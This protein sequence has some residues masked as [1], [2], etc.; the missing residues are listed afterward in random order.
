MARASFE[1]TTIFRVIGTDGRKYD[2]ITEEVA[3]FHLTVNEGKLRKQSIGLNSQMH[4][5][6]MALENRTKEKMSSSSGR[7]KGTKAPLPS[8][9]SSSSSEK[10]SKNKN[11]DKD[12]DKKK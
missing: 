7:T 3:K 6:A 8:S 1:R 12:K 11:K 9:P 5:K 2:F 10:K 4:Q